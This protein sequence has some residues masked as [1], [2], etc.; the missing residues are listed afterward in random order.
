MIRI[1][2]ISLPFDH[3][4]EAITKSILQHLNLLEHELLSFV[5]VRKS[6]DARKQTKIAVIYTI[7]VDVKD[8]HKILSRLSE[9]TNISLAQSRDYQLPKTRKPFRLHPIVVGSG[10]CGLFAA[11]ILAE[12]GLKPILIERGKDAIS[13]I[14]DVKTFWD[15]GQLNPESNVQFGEGGAGTFSDGKLYTQI[16]DKNKRSRKVLEEFVKAGAPTE[17][18]YLAKPHIGTDNLVNVVSNIRNKIISAGGEVRFQTKLTGIKVK[19]NKIVAAQVNDSEYIETEILVLALG[20]SAR[21]TFKM[22]YQQGIPMEAKPFSIGIRIEHLQSMIN[23]AQYGKF[24]S[25]QLLDPAEYKLVHH[26]SCGRSAYTFCMCPGG[27]VIASSSEPGKVVTNGMS[28]YSRDYLNANSALLVGVEPRDYESLDPLA[29]IQFQEKWEQKAF[30]L[31]GNNY[32]APVQLIGDFLSNRPST[33]L[34]KVIP[35]YTPG[36]TLSDITECLP[37]FVVQTLRLAIPQLNNKLN[38]FSMN[39]AVMTA[40]ESRSSS[41]IRFVRNESYQSPGFEGLY[42]AG[43]GAGYAGGIMS[44]AIDGIK[45]AEAICSI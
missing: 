12:L 37:E 41:P 24:A 23:K 1:R 8:E 15:I 13:R 19:N 6:I 35:S 2:N 4:P 45:I 30:K 44:S 14:K 17:I 33:S 38:G 39:D 10:P 5:I 26:T 25:N 11:L 16:K 28:N 43:E 22:L 7:D 32:F 36:I 34:G 3:K 18:L 9:D 29:G 27:K 20:H 42:P 31:G 40:I 21:S